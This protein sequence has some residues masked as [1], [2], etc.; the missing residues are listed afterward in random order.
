MSGIQWTK[1]QREAIETIDRS[2]LVSAGAGSGKTAV[3]AERCARIVD[4]ATPPCDIHELLVVTFTEAAATE[5]R[6]RIGRSLRERL[7]ARPGDRRLRRQLAFLDSANIS[8]IHAFCRSVLN[9]YFAQADIDP[10]APILDANEAS[11]LRRETIKQVF[12]DRAA[13]K[14]AEGERFLDFLAA[15]GGSEERLQL[16]LLDLDNFLTSLPAPDEWLAATLEHAKCPSETELSEYWLDELRACISSEMFAQLEAVHQEMEALAR[17][18]EQL[19]GAGGGDDFTKIVEPFLTSLAEYSEA[20]EKWCRRLAEKSDGRTIDSIITDEL[21]K[22]AFPAIPRKG[23]KIYNALPEPKQH[24]YGHA[25]DV[26][27]QVR[28]KSLKPFQE[29]WSAFTTAG[30]A[31]GLRVVGPHLQTAADVLRETRENYQAAKRELGVIDFGDLERMTL[32]LLR[33]ESNGI[34]ARL[35]NDIRYVLVDEYQDVNPIQSEIMR[36]VSREAD[37]ARAANLFTVGDVKQSIYRF[38][39]AEPQIFLDRRAEFIREGKTGAIVATGRAVDLNRNYRSTRPVIDVINA[40]FEKIM[41]ADLGGIDYDKQARLVHPSESENQSSNSIKPAEPVTTA[42]PQTDV[43]LELHVLE[44]PG[45]AR[46]PHAPE[47]YESPGS[48]GGESEPADANSSDGDAADWEQIEREAYVIA[49]RIRAEVA[50]GR[51]YGDI[52][53]LLRSM[54]ARVHLFS[55]TLGKLGIPVFADT[56]GGLFDALE[57]RDIVA[58]LQVL[59]ND[60]N[61]IPLAAVLRSPLLGEPMSANDLA[62]IRIDAGDE[63]RSLPFHAAVRKYAEGGS[64]ESLRSSLRIRLASLGEWRR[65]IRL[66]PVAD[67]LWEIYDESGYL[68][69]VCGL[70]DGLQRR[71]NLIQ[72]HEHA[73]KFGDFQRQGLSRFL[74]FL[75]DLQKTGQDLDAGSVAAPT[76]DVVRI[77]TIHRSKGLEFPVVIVG[78]LGK[79]FNLSDATGPVLYDRR[80]GIA[81]E[82][83]DLEQRIIYPTLPHR[84]VARAN[85]TE[86]LAEELRVL[87]VA[88]TRAREKLILVGTGSADV[89]L[90]AEAPRPG[91][92]PLLRRRS[93]GSALAWMTAALDA[94]GRSHFDRLVSHT[95]Y[96]ME[97]MSGWTLDPKPTSSEQEKLAALSN[98]T[99]I[100]AAEAS[101]ITP[102]AA[103]ASSTAVLARRLLTPY[104]A[105][106]LTRVPAVVAASAL[107]RRWN[108]I[109]DA[110]EP[111]STIAPETFGPSVQ[112]I[113]S[114]ANAASPS[115]PTPDADFRT[116][117]FAASG[118]D[119]TA[120]ERGTLTHEFLQRLDLARP[121][122]A[123]DLKAQLTDMQSAGLL[124]R[125]AARSIDLAAIE[126]FFTTEVGGKL[127]GRETRVLR[128]WPFVLGV[129]P[130]RFDA[131]AIAKSTDDV[132]L[133][134]GIIDCLFDAGDG[135][136]VLDYKTDR[137][138]GPALNERAA[139]YAGQIQ[140]YAAAV[141]AV[142]GVRPA[143]SW[144]VFLNARRVVSV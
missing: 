13:R 60:R 99:S 98:F 9:R 130:T 106:S 87:Y 104:P 61:D 92:L 47:V 2:V 54:K 39:L 111:I 50:A 43:A 117:S 108:T 14:D 71:A 113:S 103:S 139:L 23:T 20:L 4:E 127:L 109:A 45:R 94:L 84:L 96:D 144:L 51:T 90:G 26:L 77:M 101:S 27:K 125:E 86:M 12:D 95:I 81:L 131:R 80:L 1:E 38:R 46:A 110:D 15:Y 123:A 33:D 65:R 7:A 91:P 21:P 25:Q 122:D 115:S 141:E 10:Q 121:C 105:A 76:G 28:E 49:E 44:K 18:A 82:A 74:R 30:W 58:V 120:T 93:A 132:L 68:A 126:W 53:I 63:G 32:D 134:R 16:T 56:T 55:R 140:I 69:H 67:V 118:A 143:V 114:T 100:E 36:L 66:R 135:W 29:S 42:A 48:G 24:F 142:W 70:R 79:R 22:Y 119:L 116:P 11:I 17:R 72:L 89:I 3:L 40:I 59:D 57:T 129:E 34:A 107:K 136:Q 52:V 5:M 62:R 133:V 83:V 31:A 35:R 78:E 75:D 73:R 138:T 19:D 85:R 124:T 137:V 102:H 88:L 64:D 6:E 97:T 41:A 37:P 8:T 128:E 112:V